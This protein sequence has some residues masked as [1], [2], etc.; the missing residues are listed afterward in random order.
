MKYILKQ[1]NG[2]VVGVEFGEDI[3]EVTDQLIEA[4]KVDLCDEDKYPKAQYD[5]TAPNTGKMHS[6]EMIGIIYPA[7]ASKNVLKTYYVDEV[8]E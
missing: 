1:K 2:L 5:A 7:Y 4:V 8:Q 3:Y 6:Y